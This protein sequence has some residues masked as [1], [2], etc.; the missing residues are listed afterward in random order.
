[1]KNILNQSALWLLLL[2]WLS[3]GGQALGQR[4]QKQ[5]YFP[6]AGN[7][8]SRAPQTVGMNAQALEKAVQFAIDNEAKAPRDLKEAHYLGFGK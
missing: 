4:K 8:E 6:E 3:T 7:W 2:V 1:M 5:V